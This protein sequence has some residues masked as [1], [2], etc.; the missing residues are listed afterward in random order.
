MGFAAAAVLLLIAIYT[1]GYGRRRALYHPDP[2][3]YR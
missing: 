1:T 3:S 2:L